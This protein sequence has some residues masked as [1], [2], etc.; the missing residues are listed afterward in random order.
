MC[1]ADSSV[2]IYFFV[3]GSAW[4]NTR[5]TQALLGQF[6]EESDKPVV[7]KFVCRL[8]HFWEVTVLGPSY[9]EVMVRVTFVGIIKLLVVRP[10]G[11]R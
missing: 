1:T 4:D 9:S 7:V 3:L 8:N 5:L 10:F 2:K 6:G 11:K